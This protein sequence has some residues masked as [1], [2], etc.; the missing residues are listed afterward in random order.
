[1]RAVKQL[2]PVWMYS[3]SVLAVDY[4]RSLRWGLF[5]T[6]APHQIS[7]K[8][9]RGYK[10]HFVDAVSRFDVIIL[11]TGGNTLPGMCVCSVCVRVLLFTSVR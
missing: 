5:A 4:I 2:V 9:F 10:S 6:F 3:L 1:M 11:P 8:Q 7:R